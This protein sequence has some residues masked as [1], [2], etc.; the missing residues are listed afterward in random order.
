[1]DIANC[2]MFQPVKSDFSKVSTDNFLKLE[3][4]NKGKGALDIGNILICKEVTRHMPAYFK[5]QT[6][7]NISYTYT[8]SVPSKL[9]NYKDT[10]RDFNIHDH[11]LPTCSC[12]SSPCIYSP[13][14]HVIT[15][16]DSE[17]IYLYKNLQIILK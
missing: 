2:R 8:R 5:Y 16:S 6:A 11:Q 12:S 1:M 3:F 10:I 4:A 17:V 13:A 15:D 9:F 14:A 7:P